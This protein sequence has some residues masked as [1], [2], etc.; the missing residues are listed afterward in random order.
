MEQ[1]S[2]EWFQARL[3]KVTASNIDNV[4]VKVKNG[5]STYKRK[6][7][8][9]LITEALTNK[10]VPV[11]VND[12]MRWGTD[13][14]DEARDLYIDKK[15]LLKGEDVTE[16]GFVDHPTVNMSGASPDGLVGLNG[17]I[18]IKCPTPTTHT[19]LLMTRNIPK[20]WIYQ[21]QWQMACMPE[22]EWCD[23]VCYHPHFDG[24]QKMLII[25]VERDGD[26]ITR[27]E[28]D[29]QDFVTEVQDSVKFI[30]ENN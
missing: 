13:H 1:R 28:R 18:E 22:R 24:E 15:G 9:Q 17:L 21:M 14:E 27:L 4:I 30:K 6:Y 3:S 2:K 16:L 11:F 12:A 23:F 25:R 29:V 19:E 20:K 8:M 10:N 26:L 5:E 7:R